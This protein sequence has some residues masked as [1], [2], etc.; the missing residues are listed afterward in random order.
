MLKNSFYR[1]D[2]PGSL[3]GASQPASEYS[4]SFLGRRRGWG[5]GSPVV[6]LHVGQFLGKMAA[7]TN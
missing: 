1:R 3:R 7:I 5:M 2:L 6:G 4:F